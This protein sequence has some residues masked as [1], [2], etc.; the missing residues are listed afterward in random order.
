MKKLFF[1]TALILTVCIASMGNRI[2][3]KGQSN[4][5]FGDYKIEQLDQHLMFNNKELDEYMITYEKMGMKVLVAIDK[6][7]KCKSY[8]VLSDKLPVQYECNGKYFGIKKLNKDLAAQGYKT[9][10]ENVD[11]EE[12][13]H[14]R[15]LTSELMS[16]VDHL[17]LI[18]SYY[19]GLYNEKVTKA[20]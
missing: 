10:L 11:R 17:N 1:T 18:A 13:Y 4:T 16:T 2:V 12:F 19:P 3:S 6:Q 7:K 8:Y 9:A 5:A 15:V 14:Q 20:S